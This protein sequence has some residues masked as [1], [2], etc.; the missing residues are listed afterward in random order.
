MALERAGDW[1]HTI[2]AIAQ[3]T[4][5]HDAAPASSC[6]L[7]ASLLERLS[8]GRS[9][10]QSAIS[11]PLDRLHTLVNAHTTTTIVVAFKLVAPSER[12]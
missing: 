10:T 2:D 11:R 3:Q 1:R 7:G 8:E 6:A 4:N 5:K 12:A 9:S